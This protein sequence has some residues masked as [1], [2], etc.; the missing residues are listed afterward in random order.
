[1]IASPPSASFEAT[2][3]AGM[4]AAGA[5]SSVEMMLSH[6]LNERRPR[7]FVARL[8]GKPDFLS[9]GQLVETAVSNAL[10]MKIDLA[11]VGGDDKATVFFRKERKDLPVGRDFVN[12]SVPLLFANGVLQLPARGVE[13]VGDRYL[14]VF[15][16][17]RGAGIT[18]DMDVH[19]AGRLHMDAN[20]VRVSLVMAMLRPGDHNAGGCYALVKLFEFLGFFANPGLDGVGVANALESD[21]EG[22]LHDRLL[23]FGHYGVCGPLE[24]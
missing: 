9:H 4:R 15:M 3:G 18:V 10:P 5:P 8:L 17:S 14:D 11:A 21:Y 22:V 24:A 20:P 1:M 12:L 6:G 19:A 16:P 7:S 2:A 23:S 13:G